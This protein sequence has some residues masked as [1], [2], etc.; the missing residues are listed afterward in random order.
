MSLQES[1]ITNEGDDSVESQ[2]TVEESS[3]VRQSPIVR[4][5]STALQSSIAPTDP[6][7][8]IFIEQD[9][10]GSGKWNIRMGGK[11]NADWS[12][13]DP[14]QVFCSTP[15]HYRRPEMTSDSKGCFIRS[16]GLSVKFSMTDDVLQ[17]Q[18]VVWQHLIT[19]GINT[20]A[21]LQNPI[22]SSEVIDV[23]SL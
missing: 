1:P 7:M 21:Y 23:V 3:T 10:A 5:S 6:V 4:Q 18:R 15:F 8:G 11:P 22:D 20:I 12:G 13:L 19:H 9:P 2:P 17:F 16:T 14:K